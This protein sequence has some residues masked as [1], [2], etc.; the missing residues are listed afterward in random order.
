MQPLSAG[1]L[2]AYI[3]TNA[4][5]LH[6]MT[7][8]QFGEWI[9]AR[10]EESSR[11]EL[12]QLR[13]WIRDV[14]SANRRR[15]RDRE[16]RLNAARLA[17]EHSSPFID[18]QRISREVDSLSKGVAGL[19][20]AVREGRADAEKLQQFKE[21]LQHA[22]HRLEATESR[23]ET[24]EK[25]RFDRAIASWNRLRNELGLADAEAKLEQ[26]GDMVGTASMNAGERFETISSRAAKEIIIPSLGLSVNS[27]IILHGVT[28]G[29]PRGELDQ[30]IVTIKD[31]GIS[32][33]HAVVEAKSNINDLAHGFRV[34]QENLAWFVG[35]TRGFDPQ[36]YRSDRYAGG[37][38]GGSE[39]YHDEQGKR[40]QFDQASFDAFRELD[41]ES[42]R[43]RR[44][45]FV[46]ENRPLLGLGSG[47][48][49]RLMSRIATDYRMANLSSRTALKNLRE[50]LLEFVDPFQTSDVLKLYSV[51][52]E[53]ANHILFAQP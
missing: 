30:V 48:L 32:H 34:R 5:D 31:N 21:K 27:A 6:T 10:I 15:L 8:P 53:L 37:R 51:D 2:Q 25:R 9:A 36:L 43:L 41:H 23:L 44:L 19:T 3:A 13:C 52:Q 20:E 46:T 28:L 26:S 4:V 7:L 47:D 39:I 50:W 22:H 42:Y 24:A 14:R 40:Y 38:F 11:H 16:N 33:V 17:Y 45:Y 29:C 18:F 1:E 12:F 49:S 35:D